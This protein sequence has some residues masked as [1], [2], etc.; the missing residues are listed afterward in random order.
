MLYISIPLLSQL[1][2]RYPSGY[3][4]DINLSD[5]PGHRAN[6]PR[7]SLARA[8]IDIAREQCE[9]RK[10]DTRDAY[11]SLT[12]PDCARSAQGNDFSDNCSNPLRGVG[13]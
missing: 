3:S 2:N 10:L 4:E 12:N 8:T 11:E 9:R 13:Q 6:D 7:F 1:A 5:T